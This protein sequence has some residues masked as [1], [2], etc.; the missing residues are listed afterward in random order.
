MYKGNFLK[1]QV[2]IGDLEILVEGRAQR[3]LGFPPMF[4]HNTQTQRREV[5]ERT[6]LRD[7]ANSTAATNVCP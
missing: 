1:N 7:S 4:T 2:Q 3:R 5:G 6:T